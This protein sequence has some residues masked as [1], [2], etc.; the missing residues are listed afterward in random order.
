MP[1][2]CD[3]P[4][5]AERSD[6]GSGEEDFESSGEDESDESGYDDD[7]GNSPVFDLACQECSKTLTRR[8]VEVCLC[9]DQS[10]QLYSTD[11]P[12]DAVAL[13]DAT[14]IESCECLSNDVHCSRCRREGRSSVVGYHVTVPCAVC[15]GSGHN[16]MYW[17][18]H[19]DAVTSA[20]RDLVWSR[21]AYNGDDDASA[22][23][24]DAAG[25]AGGEARAAQSGERG[26][27]EGGSACCICAASPLW[28][29]TRIA[30]C[31]PHE[32]CF[33]CISRE[34]DARGRCPLDRNPVVREMLWRVDKGSAARERA[35]TFAR[36]Q[37]AVVLARVEAREQAAEAA[38]VAAVAA[39]A[40]VAEEEEARAQRRR[41]VN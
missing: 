16:D 28:R 3:E 12:T 30:G 38:I 19:A 40:D 6:E 36:E 2:P 34:V 39:A 31:A 10:K 32:F 5:V 14:T 33:G 9:V 27:E 35:E 37:R 18:F 7:I 24:A 26:G 41:R 15:A 1:P 11:I 25:S 22:A 8:A 23:P 13:G 29:A 4:S 21:L 17:L 20:P